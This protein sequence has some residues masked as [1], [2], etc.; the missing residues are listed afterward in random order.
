[1]GILCTEDDTKIPKQLTKWNTVG[2]R[3][4]GRPKETVRRTLARERS[5]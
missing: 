2:K 1:M 5:K 4:R 3:Q